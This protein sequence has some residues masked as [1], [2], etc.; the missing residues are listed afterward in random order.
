MPDRTLVRAALA[1][2]LASAALSAQ[3]LTLTLTGW[4]NGSQSLP[5]GTMPVGST[6]S[7]Q[8]IP[9]N[10]G[11]GAYVGTLSG[12]GAPTINPFYTYCVEL[13]E[14]FSFGSNLSGYTLVDGLT[15]FTNQAKPASAATIVQRLGQLFTLL[16]GSGL[17]ATTEQSVARQIAVWESVYEGTAFGET[18][19][20]ETNSGL[21]HFA[22]ASNARNVANSLLASAASVTNVMY[23]IQV[24]QKNGSQDFLV[25]QRI[26]EPGSLAL[27]GIALVGLAGVARRRRV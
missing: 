20:G 8:A 23:S 1:A 17:P 21:F 9:A 7:T 26:P 11:V 14:Y 12:P 19:T 27:A 5:T 24:L 2:V 6:S 18:R 16:G 22:T 10:G 25:V 13:T 4:A 3:A 15:Y